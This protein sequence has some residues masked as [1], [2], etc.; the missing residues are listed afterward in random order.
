MPGLRVVL[1]EDS[2]TIRRQIVQRLR[3]VDGLRIVGEAPDEALALAL[4]A[5]T[6]PDAVLLDL[7][8]ADGGSGLQVLK[9]LRKRGYQGQVHVLSHQTPDAYRAACLAAGANGFF[10]KADELDQVL[11]TLCG[12]VE[13]PL[14]APL[15]EAAFLA[16]LDQSAL[17]ALREGGELTLHLWRGAGGSHDELARVLARTAEPGDLVGR[18]MEDGQEM[19]AYAVPEDGDTEQLAERV[20]A[21]HGSAGELWRTVRLPADGFSGEAL[22]ELA[23]IRGG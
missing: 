6:Q 18:W 7:S 1:V 21:V 12:G 23:R 3:T 2:M 4:V 22:L 9:Q 5:H 19:V 10:D 16:R 11:Q 14:P 20:Q 13:P 8:L 17:L 15:D